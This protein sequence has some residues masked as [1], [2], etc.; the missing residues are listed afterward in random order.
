[1]EEIIAAIQ[2]EIAA[3]TKEQQ[4]CRAAQ[5]LGGSARQAG[6]LHELK[7]LLDDADSINRLP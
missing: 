2:K 4:R 3:V 6:K 5:D 7:K 1:M